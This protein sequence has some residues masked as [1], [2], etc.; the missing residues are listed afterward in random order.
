MTTRTIKRTVTFR[1]PF[2]LGDSSDQFPAGEYAVETDEDLIEGM[3]FPKYLQG[4]TVMQKIAERRPGI[5][6]RAVINPFQLDAA[7]ALDA[8]LDSMAGPAR[9]C[10]HIGGLRGETDFCG[11]TMEAP[12]KDVGAYSR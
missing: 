3:F 8:V 12:G 11:N 7:L 9:E 6:E 4:V 2:T 10:T 5:T 1:R